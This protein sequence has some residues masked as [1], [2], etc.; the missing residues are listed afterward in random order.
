M[1]HALSP[2]S[3]RRLASAGDGGADPVDG[4]R[5]GASDSG[6]RPIRATLRGSALRSAARRDHA[7]LLATV[8]GL[9][10]LGLPL[11]LAASEASSA[12]SG[13]SPYSDFIHQGVFMAIG[14]VCGIAAAR[15][16]PRTVR[17]FRFVLPLGALCLL[18]AVFL[19]G[20]GHDAG[21]SSR[22][23]G[24][25]PIQIQ[26]SELMK[27]GMI[28]FGADLLARRSSRP[29]QWRAVVVP[30]L[31]LLGVGGELIVAQPDLGTAMV[32]CCITFGLLFAGGVRLR[33]LGGVVC[34]VSV[35][36]GFFAL[37]AAY[38]RARLLSFLHPLAHASGSG[39]QVV[40]SLATL[41]MGGAAGNGVGGSQTPWG[42]LPNAHTDFV[43]AVI[44]GNLGL[45][46][47]IA[48]IGCFG[49]F[50]FVGL[51]VAMRER[52]PFM[53]LVAAGVTVWIIAQAAIN[54]GGVTDALPVTGVPLPFVSY[55][56]S[57][58][59]VAMVG[60][61]VLA[62]IAR[63]QGGPMAELAASSAPPARPAPDRRGSPRN[64]P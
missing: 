29:D 54:I 38:R 24:M 61:G 13:L 16:S 63:R 22:W 21:G 43:F 19:P 30:M 11:V 48:V 55:G 28:V 60:A 53:R 7:L 44:G 56:G 58:L 45:A 5:T 32:L 9:C 52:D 57:A 59:I 26:P 25:G 1:I 15:V 49:C 6:T 46:G 47:S 31:I 3:G 17:R 35:L 37:H 14:L 34:G 36:G 42:Y 64:G 18:V 4:A 41:G 40:Q 12:L 50:A 51:R 8:G 62:G 20:I 33:L 23:I 2:L 10:L 27:I 39:Y